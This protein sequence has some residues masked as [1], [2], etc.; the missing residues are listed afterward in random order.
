MK[1]GGWLISGSTYNR[2]YFFVYNWRA[3]KW[4]CAKAENYDIN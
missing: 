2:M 3:Y 1:A 4:G